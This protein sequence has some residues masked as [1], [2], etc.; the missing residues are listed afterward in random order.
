MSDSIAHDENTT[1]TGLGE[2]ELRD[3]FELTEETMTRRTDRHVEE[4]VAALRKGTTGTAE[5][6]DA[7]RR[8]Y[9]ALCF[10]DSDIA[11]DALVRGL[12][13]EPDE[14]VDPII[15]GLW[16]QQYLLLKR[17]PKLL[18]EHYETEDGDARFARRLVTT[19]KLHRAIEK[20]GTDW[21]RDAPPA[22]KKKVTPKPLWA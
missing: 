22:L 3:L 11:R 18:L 2:S 15:E 8:I 6:L 1:D 14:V 13:E 16:K 19:L 9:R 4:L 21:L 7:R 20:I 17:L 5:E 10:V 12:R